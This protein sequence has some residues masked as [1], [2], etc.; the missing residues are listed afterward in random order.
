MSLKSLRILTVIMGFK[1][2]GAVIF[3]ADYFGQKFAVTQ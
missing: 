3:F 1:G 2:Q